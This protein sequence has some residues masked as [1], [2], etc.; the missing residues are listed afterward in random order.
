MSYWKFDNRW[1]FEGVS[2]FNNNYG[3]DGYEGYEDL[4]GFWE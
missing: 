1:L 2:G 3:F 4:W